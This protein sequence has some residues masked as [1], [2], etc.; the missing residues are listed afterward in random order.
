LYNKREAVGVGDGG[1]GL[2]HLPCTSGEKPPSLGQTHFP[3]TSSEPSGHI[4]VI[5]LKRCKY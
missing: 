5:I 2:V 4:G 3:L 1:I